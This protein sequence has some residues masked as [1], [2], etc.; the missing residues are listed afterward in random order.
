MPQGPPRAGT[1]KLKNDRGAVG[2]G[3]DTPWAVGPAIFCLFFPKQVAAV[4]VLACNK[5]R[6]DDARQKGAFTFTQNVAKTFDFTTISKKKALWLQFKGS[7]TSLAAA[8]DVF[9]S[10]ML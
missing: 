4:G 6:L 9:F 10:K 3:S 1:S 5:G 8:T 7:P 2:A